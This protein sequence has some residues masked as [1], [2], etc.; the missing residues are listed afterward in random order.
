M[1]IKNKQLEKFLKL[2]AGRFGINEG[3][4]EE[5]LKRIYELNI[6]KLSPIGEDYQIDL[7]EIPELP[8]LAILSL[9]NFEIDKEDVK[10]INEYKNLSGITFVACSFADE[11]TELNPEALKSLSLLYC[12]NIENLK[13]SAPETLR[14]VCAEPVDLSRIV[15][16]DNVSRLDLHLSRVSGFSSLMNSLKLEEL[17]LDGS[18]YTDEEKETINRLKAARPSIKVSQKE[19]YEPTM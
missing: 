12:Q 1:E 7:S 10:K 3:L 9:R 5:D 14:V 13:Y 17:I 18:E 4:T 6:S 15:G 8:N 11:N 19:D 2:A 16:I